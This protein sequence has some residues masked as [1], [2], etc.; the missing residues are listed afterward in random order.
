MYN[1][2]IDLP[3]EKRYIG[4]YEIGARIQGLPPVHAGLLRR[5]QASRCVLVARILQERRIFFPEF[6]ETRMHGPEQAFQGQGLRRG[7]CHGACRLRGR[8]L[9]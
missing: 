6:P 8:L 1:K 7:A 2:T 5:T 9:L 4:K 3:E